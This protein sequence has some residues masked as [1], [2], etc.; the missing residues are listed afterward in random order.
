MKP[1]LNVILTHQPAS[2]VAVMLEWWKKCVPPE[3]ILLACGGSP[4]AFEAIPHAAKV[5]VDEPRE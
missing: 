4:A 2:A 1:V 5:F 3:S